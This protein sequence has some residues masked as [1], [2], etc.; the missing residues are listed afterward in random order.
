M[1]KCRICG[2]DLPPRRSKYCSPE[3]QRKKNA[4]YAIETRVANGDPAVWV[5]KGGSN[6]KFTDN[7][8][9][10][11]GMGNFHHLRKEMRESITCCERCGKDLTEAT[12][13]EWCVHHKDGDRTHNVRKN[14]EMLCK[15]CHQVHHNCHLAFNK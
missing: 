6:K 1:K 9:Y 15:G 12:R 5:G 8:Q 7:K 14:L 4:H 13:Y 3:C 10:V 11:S 2:K